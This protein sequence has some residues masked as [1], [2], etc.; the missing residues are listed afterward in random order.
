[1]TKERKPTRRLFMLLVMLLAVMP[2]ASQEYSSSVSGQLEG[3]KNLIFS[4]NFSGGSI[5]L[6]QNNGNNADYKGFIERGGTVSASGSIQ[7]IKDE[8]YPVNISFDFYDSHRRKIDSKTVGDRN[9]ASAS[10]S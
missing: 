1:M 8:S 7:N 3:G 9:A 4:F 5:K 6:L 10:P 2:M